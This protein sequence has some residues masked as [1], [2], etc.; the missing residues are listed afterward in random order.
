MCIVSDSFKKC[1]LGFFDLRNFNRFLWNWHLQLKLIPSFTSLKP[2]S[3]QPNYWTFSIFVKLL[4]LFSFVFLSSCPRYK[5]NPMLN[6]LLV[7]QILTTKKIILLQNKMKNSNKDK[8][9]KF[10]CDKTYKLDLLKY[11]KT[12]I[13]TIWKLKTEKPKL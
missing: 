10:N 9:K 4:F 3:L 8:S 7:I 2:K 13:A 1:V 5:D 12:Q 6:F 11:S